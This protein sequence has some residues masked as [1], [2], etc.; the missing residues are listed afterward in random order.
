MDNCCYILPASKFSLKGAILIFRNQM[1]G[2]VN[3]KQ[4]KNLKKIMTFS[5]DSPQEFEISCIKNEYS[6]SVDNSSLI[7]MIIISV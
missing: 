5:F 6:H 3:L 1:N 7:I 4:N 2:A